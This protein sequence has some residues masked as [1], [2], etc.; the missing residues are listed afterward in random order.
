MAQQ[1]D[2]E[3]RIDVMKEALENKTGRMETEN[4]ALRMAL[5]QL[6]KA[7]NTLSNKTLA[8]IMRITVQLDHS[9]GRRPPS[10]S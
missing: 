8:D 6:Q 4:T 3:A 7:F 1:T 2:M 9:R 10:S 5:S